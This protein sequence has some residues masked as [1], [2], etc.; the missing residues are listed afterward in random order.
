MKKRLIG[1][2]LAVVALVHLCGP[3][4]ADAPM[5][6]AYDVAAI[7]A[8]GQYDQT[9]AR[10]MLAMINAFRT[11]SDAWYWNADNRTKTYPKPE[12][13]AYDYALEEIAKQ[14]A[15]EL[16]VSFSHTRPDG[17]GCFTASYN[18]VKSQAENIA[19]CTANINSTERIFD[20]WRED[21]ENYA[22]QG[23]RR[24]MLGQRYKAVGIASFYYN[25]RYYWVQEFGVTVSGTPESNSGSGSSTG[26]G[27]STGND[28]TSGSWVKT[29][30]V[31]YYYR[32][33]TPV[34]GW[35]QDKGKW[36]Y[37]TPA[38]QTG[39]K[40]LDGKWYYFDASGAMA[41]NQWVKSKGIWY[42]LK[43]NGVMAVG[44]WV[45]DKYY[46]NSSGAMVTGWK[47]V[48]GTYYYF[49]S[50]GAKAVSQW[51]LY[52]GQWYYLKTDGK[53]AEG[54]SLTIKGKRYNFNASG[55]C[56]NPY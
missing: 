16:V 9:A 47:T 50:S 49:T 39:W 33:N 28:A 12:A 30:G 41:V 34:S 26:S 15:A 24:N 14:R 52:G 31:W 35:V 38:M 19:W 44:E 36:Y 32:N 45:H 54:E 43:S 42:Y 51:K 22:G 2:W 5:T 23:H 8:A 3:A 40:Q 27:T 4:L 25:G 20:G 17:S 29:G 13:L 10:S 56:T 6:V 7:Q 55:M 53:M 1:F 21:G 11:G 37:L 18:G 46:V 48:D